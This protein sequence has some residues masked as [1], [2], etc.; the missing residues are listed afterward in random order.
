MTRGYLNR[1]ELA[2]ARFSDRNFGNYSIRLYQTGD[3]GRYLPNGELEYLGRIDE[4]VKVRGFRIEL[5]EIEAVLHQ[6]PAIEEAVVLMRETESVGDIQPDA[7]V[8]ELRQFIKQNKSENFS[9]RQLVAYC[10]SSQQPA[11]T[12]TELRRWLKNQLPEYM[13]PTAFVMLDSLPLT[14]S[15]KVDKRALPNPDRIRPELDTAYIAPTTSA[16]KALAQIWTQV[17]RIERVG[18]HDNFFE[19]GGDSIRSIQVLAKSQEIGLNFSLQ[20]LFQHQTIYE[21]AQEVNITEPSSLLSRKTEKFSLIAAS[22]RQKTEKFSLI[23]ASDRQKLPTDIEDAYP[24]ARIQAGVIFHSQYSPDS[25]MYHD[26]FFYQL[27]VRFDVECLQQAIQQLVNRHPILRTSFDLI[28][29][30]EP[31]QLVHEQVSVPLQ[32]EDLRFLLPTQ[33]KQAI[34]T[35]IE[36]EKQRNF[37][38]TCPPMIRFFVHRLTDESFYLVL[39]FHDCILDGWSTASLL[40]ELLHRYWALL[41][42]QTYPLDLSPT[43]TYRDFVALERSTLESEECRNYW[44]QKLQDCITMQLPRW[45]HN[46]LSSTNP[47]IGVLNVPISSELFW[48]NLGVKK[49]CKA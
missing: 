4:Q 13:I 3:L 8:T 49:F 42:N 7:G 17:L 19:L 18:I 29:F 24:L 39:S 44:T 33:Q 38:W 15:G 16:E 22:D 28:N 10:V 30:S 12:I 25:P 9:D 5:G 46:S 45:D 40:T 14:P 37:D 41:H 6:H 23:A 47:E 48:G 31:L 36:T 11:P 20:Q 21:L 2:A 34:D 1:P 27:R 32:V 26:I 43:I 35:W